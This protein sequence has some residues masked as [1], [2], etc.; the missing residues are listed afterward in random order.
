MVQGHQRQLRLKVVES[1]VVASHVGIQESGDGG[2]DHDP[3]VAANPSENLTEVTVTG[4]A[5]EQVRF[6][7]RLAFHVGLQMRARAFTERPEIVLGPADEESGL[8]EVAEALRVDTEPL[9]RKA[10]SVGREH[11]E[12][13]H[14]SG[15]SHF[16]RV[17][18]ESGE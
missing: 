5:D 4:P 12:R 15:S 8:D 14:R 2:I 17:G 13:V 9:S 6:H 1:S 7:R 16:Y 3:G 18:L 10:V 11:D